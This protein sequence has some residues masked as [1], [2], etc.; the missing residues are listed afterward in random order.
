MGRGPARTIPADCA[1]KS[2]PTRQQVYELQGQADRVA[3]VV[4]LKFALNSYDS[5]RASATNRVALVSVLWSLAG[6]LARADAQQ[7]HA[8]HR[9]RRLKQ[10]PAYA[11]A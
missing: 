7:G 2:R 11:L 5:V 4:G 1:P 6:D 10:V 8:E 3:A 9:W